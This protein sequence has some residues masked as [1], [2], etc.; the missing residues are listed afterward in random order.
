MFEPII[1]AIPKD[2]KGKLEPAEMFHQLLDHRWYMSQNEKRDVPLS[3]ALTSYIDTVLRS[4][5]EEA[6]T[7][8]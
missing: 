8:E 2:L 6:L 1:R 4:K 3:E 5:K 7:A